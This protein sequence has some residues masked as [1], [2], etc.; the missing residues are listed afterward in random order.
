MGSDFCG[1][2][3]DG[4]W[5]QQN[6]PEEILPGG[7]Q[8]VATDGFFSLIV[9]TDGS[10]WTMGANDSGELGIGTADNYVHA[11]PTQIISSGV[12]AVAAG[13][14]LENIGYYPIPSPFSLILKKDGSLWVTGCNGCG[15]LG[16]GTVTIRSTPELIAECGQQIAAGWRH[17]LVVA[18]GENGATLTINSQP[19]DQVSTIGSTARFVVVAA[20]VPTPSYQWQVSTDGGNIW[21]NL[22]ET[23]P[24]SGTA[25]ETLTITGTTAAINGYQ[26]RCVATN[27]AGSVTSFAATLKVMSMTD[28][29]FLQQLFLDVVERPI[30]SSG[31]ASFG[32]ALAGGESRA[33]VLDNLFTSSEYS[34]WQVEQVIRLYYAALA[35]CPD[36]AGLQN[37]S[38]ALHAGALTLDGAGDQFAI[39]AEFLRDYGSLDNTAFVQQLY[40]NVLGRQADPAGLANWVEELNSGTSRGTVLI[41]FSESPEFQA[42]MA[43]QVE[44]IRLYY[45]LMQRMPSAA[46]LQSWI[47]FLNGDDQMDTLFTIAYPSGLSGSAYVQAVFQGFLCRAADAG[48]LSTF[49][50]GLAAGTVTHGSLVDTVLNSA[51][52]NSYVGSV[53]RLYLAAFSRIPD[54]PGLINWVNYAEAGNSLASVADTFTASQEFTNRYGAMSDTAYVTALYQN[55]LGRAPDPA[56]LTYWTGL[57]SS[58]TS[59]GGVLIGFSQSPEGISLFAPTLRT[60]LSYYAF[61]NTAPAQSDLTYWNNYL[62]TLDDQ[63]RETLLADMTTING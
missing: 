63:M 49:T 45:L 53:S 24:Y 20:G 39:S 44:I 23:M 62:T 41:G 15:Q 1:Q 61:L 22:T 37:W 43:N 6:A 32:T 28:Q 18:G 10:L 31:A 52:F 16:D 57:L 2:L 4:T 38:K 58:G 46:E 19:T 35:R 54:Q 34:A 12:Q 50:N 48:A 7:V 14:T 8:A 26:Y 17:S 30:D 11:T 33:D 36:Y 47:A 21:T 55:V 51:E 60:F 27:A 25:T 56:G 9:R 3:G 40:L 5:E 42:D 29:A 13:G 59:R